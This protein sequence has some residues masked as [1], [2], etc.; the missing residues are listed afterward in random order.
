M[1]L[2]LTPVRR[3]IAKIAC[4]SLTIFST[5][6]LVAPALAEPI[7][8]ECQFVSEGEEFIKNPELSF[9]IDRENGVVQWDDPW[10][11]FEILGE[12]SSSQLVAAYVGGEHG[13]YFSFTLIL[14][15]QATKATLIGIGIEGDSLL[16]FEL[17]GDCFSSL[18][19]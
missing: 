18:P 15:K 13:S 10:H 6:V 7:Q 14:E 17:E 3:I 5:F 12:T 16:R 19:E 1:S 9:L 4:Y 2:T 8:L 11:T